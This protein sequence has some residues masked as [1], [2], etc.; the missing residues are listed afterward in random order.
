MAAKT[1]DSGPVLPASIESA[2]GLRERPPKGPRPGMSVPTIVDAAVRVADADGLAAVSMSRVAKELGAATMALYR[3]VGSKDEL[4]MLMV[5][6]GYGPPPGP[7]APEDDWRAA[8]TRWAWAEHEALRQRSWLLHVPIS[9]PP[10]TPQQLG[11]ME[12]GL[13]CLDGT[14]LGEGEKMSVLLLITGYVRNEA[15]LTSQVAEGSRAAGVE[16][17]EM[18]PA[19]GRL[20]ARLID[21]A[22]F[23]AL[24]RVLSAGVLAQDDDPDDEFTFGLDRILDGVEALIRRRT[25]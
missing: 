22:R 18:M 21:P 10:I 11:W 19:Y 14:A 13:R 20:V 8:L 9:G 6:T 7:P 15:T 24:H 23:P 16:P 3:Y 25:G 5:D 17:S 2:W 4:L 1:D 12:D